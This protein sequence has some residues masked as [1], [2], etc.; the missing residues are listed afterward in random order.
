M[1]VAPV[2]GRSIFVSQSFLDQIA[3]SCQGYKVITGGVDSL[4]RGV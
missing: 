3:L 1:A 4:R 2:W